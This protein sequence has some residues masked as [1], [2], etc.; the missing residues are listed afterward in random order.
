MAP[1]PNAMQNVQ[2]LPLKMVGGNQY[3][4]YKKISNEETFNFIVSDDALVPYAGYKAIALIGSGL[5]G[6]GLWS[7]S[8]G[9]IMLGIWGNL[10]F[11]LNSSLIASD[12]IG[13][14]AT[15][16]GDVFISENNN[17]EICI[18]DKEYVYVYNWSTGVFYSNQPGAANPIVWEH[19]SGNPGYISYQNG[20]LI[21]AL[22]GTQEWVLSGAN[23]ATIWK[24]NDAG[25]SF[26]GEWQNKPSF[27]IAAVPTPGGGNNMLLLGQNGASTWQFTGATLFPYQRNSGN[28]IDYGCANASSIAAMGNITAW[29]ATS[30]LAGPTIM[31]FDGAG[32]NQI[33]T[34]GI[35]YQLAN[36]DYPND[37]TGF[38]FRQDGHVIYQFTFVKDNLSFAYDF[39]TK[40]F[41]TITDPDLNYHPARQV[42]FF[43]NEYYFVSLNGSNLYRFGTQYTDAILS[44]IDD[45]EAYEIPR[46]RITP[47]FRLPS[48]RYFIVKS[49]GFT[50]ENGQPN[51]ITTSRVSAIDNNL[52][53]ED[54]FSLLTEN[55]NSITTETTNA[56]PV[57]ET[58]SE[59]V[60]LSISRDGGESFGSSLR[61]E[62]NNVGKRKSRFIFQRLGQCNDFTAQIRFTGYKRFVCF[63]GQIE[64]YQ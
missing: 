16:T 38:L 9:N 40:L 4:R 20:Y 33:S 39:N 44:V 59:A 19:T 61:L 51:T 21:I 54:L 1:A 10:V 2:E 8:A 42:V 55:G 53:T 62:M 23:K 6:R 36:L 5:I 29:V 14:L 50:I 34:D 57:Y 47:P 17:K 43:N 46:I 58:R 18:T 56:L 48:Q 41:F 7:S 24:T 22:E 25:V 35:N 28:S 63:E 45:S 3:G 37:C 49:L 64:V 30:D 52:A 27:V 12:P 31:Y 32:I 26:V 11:A 15:S 13:T 60:D